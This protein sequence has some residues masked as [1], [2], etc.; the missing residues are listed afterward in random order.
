MKENPGD[1][2]SVTANACQACHDNAATSSRTWP[3]AL[4]RHRV[5]DPR[6]LIE[7]DYLLGWGYSS[8]GAEHKLYGT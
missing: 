8:G 2:R 4:A 1:V 6:N 3:S 7:R 5:H